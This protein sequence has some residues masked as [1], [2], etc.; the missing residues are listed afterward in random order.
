MRTPKP[1]F[2]LGDPVIAGEP[3]DEPIEGFV[4]GIRL[5]H[6]DP[7][8][9][10]YE[11]APDPYLADRSNSYHAAYVRPRLEVNRAAV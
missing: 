3:F 9:V 6:L 10:I 2:N 11:V 1:K 7:T 5:Y 4:T 8:K